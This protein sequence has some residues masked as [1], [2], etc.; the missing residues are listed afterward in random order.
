MKPSE[1]IKMLDNGERMTGNGIL[2]AVVKYLDE[3]YEK[4]AC[5]KG[6]H[7]AEL[8]NGIYKCKRCGL[9]FIM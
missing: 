5:S 2:I 7:D 9:E 4:T 3:E 6:E 8:W 1:R